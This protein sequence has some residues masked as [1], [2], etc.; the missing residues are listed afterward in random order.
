MTNRPTTIHTTC[1]GVID[2]A[3]VEWENGA[4]SSEVR[5]LRVDIPVMPSLADDPDVM[6]ERV[7]A[8]A[9]ACG[10]TVADDAE[11]ELRRHFGVDEDGEYEGIA[12]ARVTL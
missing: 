9:R 1:S 11:I 8:S 5:G 4:M 10:Y 2:S 6:R 7:I 12:I 3:S